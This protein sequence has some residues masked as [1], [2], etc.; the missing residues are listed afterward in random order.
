MGKLQEFIAGIDVSG[1]TEEVFVSD[2]FQSD[3]EILKFKISAISGDQFAE[4]QKQA[5]KIG[6]KGSVDFNR[7]KL[8]ELIV[9]GH[10]LEPDFRDAA[11][12]KKAGCVTPEQLLYKVLLAGEIQTLEA[13]ITQLSGFDNDLDELREEAKN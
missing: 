11:T 9:L 4:Y 8:T 10:T 1:I 5:T 2:R 6:K 7:R 13:A 12:I 3:G